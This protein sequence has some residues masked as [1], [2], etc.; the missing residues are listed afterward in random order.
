MMRRMRA[1]MQK[2]GGLGLKG[3]LRVGSGRFEPYKAPGE[4]QGRQ[5]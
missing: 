4:I 5:A 3:E 1:S 2:K